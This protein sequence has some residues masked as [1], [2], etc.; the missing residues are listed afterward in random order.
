MK[1]KERGLKIK[2]NKLKESNNWKSK[3]I[4]QE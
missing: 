3:Q 1:H 2:Q 4:I